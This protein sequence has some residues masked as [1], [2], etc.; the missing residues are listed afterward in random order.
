MMAFASDLT[1]LLEAVV[2]FSTHLQGGPF[3][4]SDVA[5]RERI[6]WVLPW[7]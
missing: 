5:A 6:V 2:V 4:R 1:Q 3:K 7:L